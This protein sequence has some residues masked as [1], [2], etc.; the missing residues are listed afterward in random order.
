MNTLS[1][2]ATR[3]KLFY[4]LFEKCLTLGNK[5]F[6]LK[7]GSFSEVD[8]GVGKWTVSDRSYLSFTKTLLRMYKMAKK[9]LSLNS[10]QILFLITG[11]LK[12]TSV[13]SEA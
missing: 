5:F 2:E 1:G 3:L 6:L 8:H 7:E 10:F 9:L 11:L 12:N 4:L 13:T